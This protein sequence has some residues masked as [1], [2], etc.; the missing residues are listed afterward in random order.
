MYVNSSASVTG[1]TD[2]EKLSSSSQFYINNIDVIKIQLYILFSFFSILAIFFQWKILLDDSPLY[3]VQE[4]AA[5][6]LNN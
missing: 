4:T 6:Q 1:W 5:C 3:G 2:M